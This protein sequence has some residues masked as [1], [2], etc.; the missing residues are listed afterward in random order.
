MAWGAKTQIMTTQAVAP[1]IPQRSTAVT[2]NPGELAH[3]QVVADFPAGLND[4][5]QV[6]V[7]GTLDDATEKWDDTPIFTFE[8]DRT[9]A[10]PGAQ[11]FIVN[12]LYRFSIVV[13]IAGATDTIIVDIFYRADGV[14]L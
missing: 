11:S 1:G 12:D 4:N 9:V 13:S 6:E 3:I 14:N 10:D 2:L 8:V 7:Q 5:L